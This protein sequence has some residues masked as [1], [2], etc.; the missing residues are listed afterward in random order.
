MKYKY[1][2]H[3]LVV[4]SF[5]VV[6]VF[7][8]FSMDLKQK[9]SYI[10]YNNTKMKKVSL[11][12]QEG[13]TDN[14]FKSWLTLAQQYDVEI[15]KS[16]ITFKDNQIL[17][18]IYLTGSIEDFLNHQ[19]LNYYTNQDNTLKNT[20][21]T[22]NDFNSVSEF[23]I[24][25][26]L[27]NDVYIFQ[28]LSYFFESDYYLFSQY[29]VFYDNDD[30]F[31]SFKLASNQLFQE[32]LDVQDINEQ[33]S[34]YLEKIF[35]VVMFLF[36]IVYIIVEIFN[37]YYSSKQISTLKMLGFS[38]FKICLSLFK[39]D[40]I[41]YVIT[42]LISLAISLLLLR[43]N[44]MKWFYI[45]ALI[46]FLII[47][48]YGLLSYLCICRILSKNNIIE[49]LKNKGIVK[50]LLR[51][52]MILEFSLGFI[53]VL[54]LSNTL[55]TSQSL[56]FK[57][58]SLNNI[59][60]IVNY[61]YFPYIHENNSQISQGKKVLNQLYSKLPSTSIHYEYSSFSDF[62]ISEPQDIKRTNQSILS[63]DYFPYATVDTNYITL[64]NIKV[65]DKDHN[66]V[67]LDHLTQEL[68]LFPQE[69]VQYYSAFMKYYQ[70]ELNRN[71]QRQA[72]QTNFD[73]YTY[74]GETLL[75]TI[76]N[77][78]TR[79]FKSPVIFEKPI[80]RV[81]YSDYPLNYIDDS[82]GLNIAGTGMTIG[83]KFD[84]QT[85]TK[86]FF[87]QMLFPLLQEAKVEQIL[88]LNLL[89]TIGE[90]IGQEILFLQYQ[91]YLEALIS[92]FALIVYI[93]VMHQLIQLTIQKNLKKIIV[94]TYLG[95]SKV[96]IYKKIYISQLLLLLIPI[97]LALMIGMMSFD[98][99][100]NIFIFLIF[101]LL[102]IFHC[103]FY[104]SLNKVKL[105]HI[106]A[107]LK[108]DF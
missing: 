83:L 45:E 26:I 44:Y 82:L 51:M 7:F 15:V 89:T 50:K 53:V 104:A 79:V 34:S 81:I 77:N 87:Y 24:N 41:I 10:Q 62:H 19:S 12:Y 47:V 57:N 42:Y 90:S 13:I 66:E 101:F 32:E 58:K 40:M 37:I 74:Q 70:K 29:T 65:F 35:I 18:Q 14:T 4:V 59:M 80:L 98:I 78:G 106:V 28:P 96:R 25:D 3:F 73:L 103:L 72:I 17:N 85:Q 48:L 6:T 43:G 76:E 93:I 105:N 108:G 63:G 38:N 49:L 75:Y 99:K 61:A 71:E 100:L 67:V 55:A 94:K 27:N 97:L 11:T 2:K 5:L 21:S 107:F 102:T 68:F 30:N 9:N 56:L 31:N 16:D 36:F 92:V 64:N 95:I 8:I 69:Y 86:E 84:M 88:P 20:A 23:K 39:T 33:N 91:L 46:L 54:L 60:D 52:N 22:F 1:I